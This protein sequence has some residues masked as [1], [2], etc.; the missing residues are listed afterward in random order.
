M[1]KLLAFLLL[2]LSATL[3]AAAQHITG[4]I[5]DAKTGETVPFVNVVY[6]GAKNGVQSDVDGKYSIAFH[7]GKLTFSCV[8]Y[9]PMTVKP[10]PGEVLDIKLTPND[11][12]FGEIKVVVKKEK[13][14]RKNNPAVDLMRK[15]IEAK[16]NSDL[17]QHDFYTVQQYNKLNFALADVTPK[18]FEEGEFKSMPF[19]KEHVE[20][21]PETGKLILPLT[22]EETVTEMMYRKS[23]DLS[24]NLVI[25]KRQEGINQLFNTGD[26]LTQMLND[27][28]TEVN[29]YDDNIR[30]LQYQFISPLS[31][32]DAISFYHYFITDTCY[33]DATKCIEL[34]FT[35][36]NYM[37]FGFS[38]SLFVT[39]DSTYRLKRAA[40]GV[41]VHT[42]IN[43]V[44][45]MKIEQTYEMLPSGEQVLIKDDM[46]L[47]MKLVKDNFKVQAKRTTEYSG[48]DFSPIAESTLRFKGKTKVLADAMMKED[49]FWE[50]HR[51]EKL[52][53]S[54]SRVNTFLERVQNMKYFKPVVWV[55]K[56]FIENYVETTMD[57]KKGSKIDYGPVNTTIGYNDVDGL[58]LRA[59]ILSTANLNPHLFFKGYVAY[60]FGDQR[61]K[62]AGEVTYSFN[63]KKYL[64]REFPVRNL[65]FSYTNDVT[66]P[67]DVHMPT[68]KDNFFIALKWSKVD[69]MVYNENFKLLYD[70]E[71][72]NGL[73]MS[74]KLSHDK[75]E[76]TGALFY[77]PVQFGDHELVRPVGDHS[78]D[79]PFLTTT[80]FTFSVQYQPGAEYLNTKQRRILVNKEAPLFGLSHTVGVKGAWS[81]F[82]YNN[83]EFEIYKRW[84][85]H[86][87]GKIDTRLKAGAQWNKV[88][89]PLLCAP[90]ANTSYIRE[91]NMFN[92]IKNMEFLNDRYVSFMGQWDLN[93]KILNRIPLIRRL[94]WREYFGVNALWGHLTDKNNP[95]L[96]QNANSTEL[97]YFP[98]RTLVDGSYQQQTQV[99]NPRV[100]YVEA[101]VG[102]HNIFKLLW[103]QYVHRITY[104][105][106]ATSIYG[107]T[108]K[109]GIRFIFK[110]TF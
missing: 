36:A 39:A 18:V 31:S 102:I 48:F 62:G 86:S 9:A 14:S 65:T 97:Y 12:E 38:G 22:V 11:Y 50:N 56:A 35:P 33:I 8:G 44:D 37:D 25:G 76:P 43:F 24:K 81:D 57:P 94:K 109:W 106:D 89:Y 79:I 100:P 61:W 101:Y 58:R 66:S 7:N 98:S 110:A 6:E 75:M 51:S 3:T 107:D 87:W 42:G 96:A 30:L 63:K 80:D 2:I 95:Y 52:T 47:V 16:R 19:L 13:Y 105:N 46:L 34:Q 49:S 103:V 29:L 64:P 108:Q 55:G 72:E 27:F 26:M 59:S 99:M 53:Q 45:L 82:T 78:H 71:W 32:K 41:P 104:I 92:L 73:R 5:T 83:T 23:D 17:H 20:V 85:V 91:D 69:H 88:P 10:K 15:V 60:G 67:S 28:F 93:G 1:K 54:E 84:W 4:H 68:D 74:W 21:S 40:I 70:N 77:Q 90:W